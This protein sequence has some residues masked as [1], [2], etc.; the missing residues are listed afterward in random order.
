MLNTFVI[1]IYLKTCEIK[2]MQGVTSIR[3]SELWR[4]ERIMFRFNQQNATNK[5][6]ALSINC[7]K[8]RA[9]YKSKT[10]CFQIS[11]FPILTCGLQCWLMTER[12]RSRVQRRKWVSCEK[13]EV[14]PNLTHNMAYRV[15]LAEHLIFQITMHNRVLQEICGS[16]SQL[17]AG[18]VKSY[19]L[20]LEDVLLNGLTTASLPSKGPRICFMEQVYLL[21]KAASETEEKSRE[22]FLKAIPEVIMCTNEAKRSRIAAFNLLVNPAKAFITVDSENRLFVAN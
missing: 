4:S 5:M 1:Q 8:M 6:P 20:E 21:L 14:Y 13:L 18:F 7:T 2:L 11:F 17:C 9:V 19:L 22:C 3:N 15:I 16:H 12:V 10:F